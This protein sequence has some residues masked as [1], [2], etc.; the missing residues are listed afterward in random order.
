MIRIFS[1][2]SGWWFVFFS[3]SSTIL[4]HSRS[5]SSFPL[6]WTCGT[7]R[8]RLGAAGEPNVFITVVD[9]LPTFYIVLIDKNVINV[10]RYHKYSKN[11]SEQ[12]VESMIRF[13]LR[14]LEYIWRIWWPMV[15][16]SRCRLG[17]RSTLVSPHALELQIA[18]KFQRKH[19]GTAN[20]HKLNRPTTILWYLMSINVNLKRYLR[21]P[22]DIWGVIHYFFESFWCLDD[23]LSF[24]VTWA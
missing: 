4:R 6:K 24:F 19:D 17:L 20:W 10:V 23:I 21:H 22:Q 13:N 5:S 3:T 2:F 8:Q 7:T 9:L 12:E 11:L 18:W 1:R 16:S 15:Q 14:I